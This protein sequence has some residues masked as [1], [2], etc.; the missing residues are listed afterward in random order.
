MKLLL[1][2]RKLIIGIGNNIEYGV[3]GN[4]DDVK[5]W[6]IT[7]THYMMDGDFHL[8]DIGDTEIPTYVKEGQ[9][10]F[11][12]GEFKLADECPNEYKDRITSLEEQLLLTDETAVE[13]YET[14]MAQEEINIAQDEALV[15]IYELLGGM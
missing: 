5:S 1:D 15:E 11:I 2:S 8:E 13:L 12:N 10:Y 6:R 3:W 9:Y 7:P 4:M 14:Q